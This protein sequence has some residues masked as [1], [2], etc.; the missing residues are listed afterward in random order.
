V[1]LHRASSRL[2]FTLSV[3][4]FWNI[5]GPGIP[6]ALGKTLRRALLAGRLGGVSTEHHLLCYAHSVKYV[7]CPSQARQAQ[8]VAE[9][10][11]HYEKRGG[12]LAG[13]GSPNCACCACADRVI[14]QT[15][16]RLAAFE[17]CRPRADRRYL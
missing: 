8:V 16:S 4:S 17:D 12:Q 2:S 5:E 6:L 14:Y 13:G 1:Q 15:G 11:T 3:D 7:R 9:V 10:E